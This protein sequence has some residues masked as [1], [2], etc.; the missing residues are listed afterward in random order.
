ME[1]LATIFFTS[2]SFGAVF[3]ICELCQ[4]TT[5]GCEKFDDTIGQL[6]W[7]LLPAKLQRILPTVIMYVQEPISVECFGSIACDRETFKRVVHG[8]FSYFM[9]FREINV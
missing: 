3:V 4:R 6:K 5:N 1:L 8:G 9:V 7:Y 2:Y